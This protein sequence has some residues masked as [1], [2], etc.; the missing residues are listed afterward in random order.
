MPNENV[1]EEF[2]KLVKSKYT[3]IQQ[4]RLQNQK[5]SSLRDW[6]LPML[7]NGQVSGG[8]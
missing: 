7:M 4:N 2:E 5:L 6:L 3:K 1:A 8:E